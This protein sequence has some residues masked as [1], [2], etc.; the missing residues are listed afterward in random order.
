[1]RQ[2]KTY[3]LLNIRKN[4]FV[5]DNYIIEIYMREFEESLTIERLGKYL[6]KYLKKNNVNNDKERNDLE[7]RKKNSNILT[8]AMIKFI[9]K[10][11]YVEDKL[12]VRVSKNNKLDVDYSTEK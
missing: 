7:M 6:Y 3:L 12:S 2:L 8:K 11:R 1:M 9:E 4:R 5:F 10:E